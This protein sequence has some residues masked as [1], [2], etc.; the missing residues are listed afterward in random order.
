MWRRDVASF[1]IGLAQD[2]DRLLPVPMTLVRP[3][4]LAEI[5]GAIEAE[6]PEQLVE[7]VLALVGPVGS[8][9]VG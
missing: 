6:T 9:V 2:Y 5:L 3:E 4:Y 8:R 1:A 7:A